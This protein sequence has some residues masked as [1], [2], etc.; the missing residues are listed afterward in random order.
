VKIECS[1]RV[2]PFK[3]YGIA[4]ADPRVGASAGAQATA[5]Q[6]PHSNSSNI[7]LKTCRGERIWTSV[8]ENLG[9][10]SRF[11]AIFAAKAHCH[12]EMSSWTDFTVPSNGSVD[13]N[14]LASG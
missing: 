4:V 5:I 1:S 3:E 13:E 7:N 6:T 10:P 8:P 9:L 2:H 14:R 12:G 11:A